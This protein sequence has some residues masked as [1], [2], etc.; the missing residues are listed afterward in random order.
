MSNDWSLGSNPSLYFFLP[1]RSSKWL[2][3]WINFRIIFLSRTV[4][5]ENLKWF[6]VTKRDQNSHPKRVPRKPGRAQPK[7]TRTAL[8]FLI[9]WTCIFLASNAE[10]KLFLETTSNAL[11]QVMAR[12][13]KQ[14]RM[15]VDSML[16]VVSFQTPPHLFKIIFNTQIFPNLYK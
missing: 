5:D 6:R 7:K 3:F 8:P 15:R 12:Q 9:H 2:R 10:P 16:V 11:W 13:E 14:S 4:R 1:R